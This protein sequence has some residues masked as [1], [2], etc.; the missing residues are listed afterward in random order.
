MAVVAEQAGQALTWGHRTE[1]GL[2]IAVVVKVVAAVV[3]VLFV[4]VVIDPFV[5]VAMWEV[6]VIFPRKSL[7]CLNNISDSARIKFTSGCQ[8]H[9]RFMPGQ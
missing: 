7:S 9:S 3:A 8:K 6:V 1:I 4:I 5:V 2:L